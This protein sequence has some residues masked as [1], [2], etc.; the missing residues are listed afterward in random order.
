MES[1]ARWNEFWSQRSFDWCFAQLHSFWLLTWCFKF[2]FVG[3]RWIWRRRV[4]ARSKLERKWWW[5]SRRSGRATTSRRSCCCPWWVRSLLPPPPWNALG[6]GAWKKREFND[7]SRHMSLSTYIMFKF[8]STV[9][10]TEVK[11]AMFRFKSSISLVNFSQ[12]SYL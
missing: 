6:I 2:D 11:L 8:P 3:S 4:C 5:R 9:W 7:I 1:R 10:T 12:S